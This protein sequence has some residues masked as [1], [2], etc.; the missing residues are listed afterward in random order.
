MNDFKTITFKNGK[1][2][3]VTQDQAN[4]ISEG[5]HKK[6]TKGFSISFYFKDGTLD[7]LIDITEIAFIS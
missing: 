1:T 6:K 3:E 5:V 7:K 2:L 4:A